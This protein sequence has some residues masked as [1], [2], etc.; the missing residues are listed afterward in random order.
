MCFVM[1]IVFCC[2]FRIVFCVLC[3]FPLFSSNTSCNG[4]TYTY[5]GNEL[6]HSMSE[7]LIT[8]KHLGLRVM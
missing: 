1:K 2:C 3:F 6:E 8:G 7:K 5:V 4:D